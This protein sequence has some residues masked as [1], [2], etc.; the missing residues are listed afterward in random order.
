MVVVR[1]MTGDL[2]ECQAI[3]KD[4][5]M[6]DNKMQYF[7]VG[8]IIGDKITL[9]TYDTPENRDAVMTNIYKNMEK[10]GVE[11]IVEDQPMMRSTSPCK[12]RYL[13][14]FELGQSKEG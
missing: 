9:G 2:V 11:S 8:H 10:Y 13:K 5:W 4:S 7:I 14:I 6:E 3:T 1:T 12:T